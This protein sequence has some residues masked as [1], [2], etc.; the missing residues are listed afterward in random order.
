MLRRIAVVCAFLAALSALIGVAALARPSTLR[1][2]SPT[3]L[4]LPFIRNCRQPTGTFAPPQ[5]FTDNFTCPYSGW[6]TG[7]Y[8]GAQGNPIATLD[9]LSGAF[10]ILALNQ[11]AV[12]YLIPAGLDA[13]G[14]SGLFAGDFQASVQ[15]WAASPSPQGTSGFYFGANWPQ[16]NSDGTCVRAS[17]Y[18]L[19]DFEVGT[20]VGPS[21]QAQS[22]QFYLARFNYDP[23]DP[24]CT[25]GTWCSIY[26]AQP[27]G[28]SSPTTAT[29]AALLA[30]NG[31][32]AI[33][34]TRSGDT[35]TL[36]ANGQQLAQVTDSNSPLPAQGYLGLDASP[37]APDFD[38]R[39]ANFSFVASAPTS[40]ATVESRSKP[41]ARET[42][43]AP[44]KR[45]L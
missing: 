3:N 37:A 12:G 30:G 23:T 7:S 35:I 32:N 34:V 11:D 33:R 17:D 19:Y 4:Y 21:G 39:F 2:A 40:S 20:V 18:G 24:T 15:V 10:Q 42:R 44:I 14:Y 43:P 36:S 27:C 31:V 13:N 5:T 25:K 26:P 38:A 9:Y 45:P 28:A 8:L 16:Y 22:S 29:S 6:V 1:A 41:A